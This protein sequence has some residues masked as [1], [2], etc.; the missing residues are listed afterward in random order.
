MGRVIDLTG[1]RF[2]R[3]LVMHR[4]GVGV[5]GNPWVCQCDCGT[6]KAIKSGHLRI[7][8]VLSCGCWNSEVV[9]RRNIENA[10]HRHTQ[11]GR[12]TPTYQTWQCMRR[13]CLLPE[14][15]DFANYGGRGIAICDE[16]KD[17]FVQFLADMGD[18]P[19]GKTIDRID[20][21]GNYEPGNCRWA[22]PREQSNNKRIHKHRQSQQYR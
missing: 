14:D 1:Q 4:V 9:T 21:D 5:V 13:R 7:E 3:L 12:A 15:K 6:V 19:A 18:R 22:T 10:T 20:V 17:S 16:W 2:G 11:N 8:R